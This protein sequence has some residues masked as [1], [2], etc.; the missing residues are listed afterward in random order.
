MSVLPLPHT[1]TGTS[2]FLALT[3]FFFFNVT[4]LH[5]SGAQRNRTGLGGR[6]GKCC[7]LGTPTSTLPACLPACG[8]LPEPTG[9][10]D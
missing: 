9:R 2:L 4:K 10:G 3:F 5:I 1:S 7:N 8:L 6:E